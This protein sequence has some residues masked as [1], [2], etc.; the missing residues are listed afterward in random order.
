[1]RRR[2]AIQGNSQ[3]VGCPDDLGEG[4]AG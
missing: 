3:I 4:T 1:M 2:P